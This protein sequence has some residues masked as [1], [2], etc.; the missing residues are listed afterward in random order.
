MPLLPNHFRTRDDLPIPL[1]R[2]VAPPIEPV[3]YTPICDWTCAPVSDKPPK[4]MRLHLAEWAEA[5]A[6][7][8]DRTQEFRGCICF[9]GCAPCCWCTHPGNPINL[10]EDDDAWVMGYAE[11]RS[12]T[13][14]V[15]DE[16]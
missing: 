12:A 4:R 5:E 7:D 1:E 16:R 8:F 13:Q 14:G 9:T 11:T 6:D 2:V 10:A 15:S 3:R